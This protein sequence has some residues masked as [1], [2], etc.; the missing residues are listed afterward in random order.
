MDTIK[1]ADNTNITET[2]PHIPWN[3]NRPFLRL[4]YKQGYRTANFF[5]EMIIH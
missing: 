2:F 3:L 4:I 1:S 5:Q